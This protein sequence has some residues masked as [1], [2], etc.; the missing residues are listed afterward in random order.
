ML[1]FRSGWRRPLRTSS[2]SMLASCVPQQYSALAQLLVSQS[3]FPSRDDCI[4]LIGEFHV[5]SIALYMSRTR[6]GKGVLVGMQ[7]CEA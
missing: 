3:I 2:L 6:G 1:W 7:P 5:A 4:R